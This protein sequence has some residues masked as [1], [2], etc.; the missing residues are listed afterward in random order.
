[1]EG[2]VIR[3]CSY[4]PVVRPRSRAAQRH[5]GPAVTAP[6]A[7]INSR[8]QLRLCFS[9]VFRSIVPSFHLTRYF[10]SHAS[11]PFRKYL[12]TVVPKTGERQ[13]GACPGLPYKFLGNAAR[14]DV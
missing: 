6:E 13:F 12:R 10:S 14:A 2:N 1:M 9:L 4:L 5:A 3:S 7:A 11:V 8:S